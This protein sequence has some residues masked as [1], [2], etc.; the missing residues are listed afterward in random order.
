M[1]FI[2]GQCQD[3]VVPGDWYFTDGITDIHEECMADWL[4]EKKGLSDLAWQYGML[5]K[6]KGEEANELS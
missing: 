5:R 4:T 2:C 1:R 6:R 3:A